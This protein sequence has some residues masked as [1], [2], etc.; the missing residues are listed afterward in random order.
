MGVRQK[1]RQGRSSSRSRWLAT[2]ALGLLVLVAAACSSGSS[3]STTTT[4]ANSSTTA[5]SASGP[6]TVTLARAGSLGTVLVNS[7]GMTLYHFTVDSTGKSNCTGTCASI[8]A[9]VVVPAGTTPAGGAGLA[10]GQ[11]GTI[12]RADGTIQ[13]TYKGMP[14]YTYMGDKKV[15]DATGQGVGSTWFVITTSGSPV[16]AGGGTTTTTRA[17]GSGGYGY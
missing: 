15:G 2:G 10:R 4:T 3:S 1:E 5:T 17:G 9:P 11:L 16:T 6:A 7:S 13:V 14:L 12:T 8:W